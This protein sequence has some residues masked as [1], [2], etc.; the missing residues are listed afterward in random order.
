MAGVG[1]ARGAVGGGLE[2]GVTPAA[3]AARAEDDDLTVLGD[4]SAF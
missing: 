4:L 2:V 3:V 1:I